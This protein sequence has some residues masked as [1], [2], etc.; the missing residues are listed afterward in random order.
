MKHLLVMRHAKSDWT[1]GVADHDRPLSRRGVRASKTMGAVL[2]RMGQIPDL[3][4]SSTAV[5]ART[6]VELAAEAGDWDTP[7]EATQDLYGTSAED[8]LAVASKAP[9]DVERLMLVGHQPTWGALVYR[10]TGGAVQ[11]KTATIVAIECY[12]YDWSD[13]AETHG[14]VLYVLQ[15]R[16]FDDPA[17]DRP[18]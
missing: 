5:R 2:R 1:G 11:V 8:A 4:Y 13:L 14:E 9:D 17:W 15:A 10:L 16:L 7:I 12:A 3:V 18:G 6:T